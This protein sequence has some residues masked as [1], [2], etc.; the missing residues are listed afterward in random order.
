MERREEAFA[1]LMIVGGKATVQS[2][3][4]EERGKEEL[5][6]KFRPRALRAA[7]RG[8]AWQ[9]RRARR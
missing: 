2:R 5:F 6:S 7:P 1:F 4:G 8:L 3:Y 9:M